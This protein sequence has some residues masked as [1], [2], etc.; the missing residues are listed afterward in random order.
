MVANFKPKPDPLKPITNPMKTNCKSSMLS[1]PFAILLAAF[2]LSAVPALAA[3]Y[4]SQGSVTPT[5]TANWNTVRAGGG[6]SPGN[7]TAGD[8][9]V[10][11]S[12]HNMTT[13][14]ARTITIDTTGRTVGTLNIGDPTTSFFAYT[15]AASGGGTLTSDLR[16]LISVSPLSDFPPTPR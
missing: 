14:A 7:F 4:F 1:T 10:I 9:F 2:V 13:T 11:Q 6:T 16:P 15:L 8:I 5:A 3:T 12:P